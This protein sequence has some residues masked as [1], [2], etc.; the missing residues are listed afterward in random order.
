MSRA[1][2]SLCLDNSI[3]RERCFD[4]SPFV[5]YI[6]R[7][8]ALFR[9]SRAG[10]GESSDDE[11][12]ELGGRNRGA[13]GRALGAFERREQAGLSTE[14]QRRSDMD[15]WDPV[16]PGERVSWYNEYIQ[17][18]GPISVSWFQQSRVRDGG[19]ED[20][21][22]VRGVAL[23][24]PS[25]L[26]GSR[27]AVSPLDDGSVCLWDVSGSRGR[28]G[29]I[30]AKSKPGILFM[31]GPGGANTK[32]SKM[33]D[34]GVT[35]CVA[36]DSTGNRAFVAVQSRK[37][38]GRSACSGHKLKDYRPLGSRPSTA[39]NGEVRVIPVVDNCAVY[40]PPGQAPNGRH[41]AGHPSSRL[42][43]EKSTNRQRCRACR[44]PSRRLL[45]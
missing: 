18:S 35:E 2:R 37:S 21:V 29:A 24:S 7:K 10:A 39:G 40:C 38:T 19:L 42:S 36:V 4:E 17:R 44:R 26:P 14:Q 22:D 28:Q 1:L 15:N 16:F 20:I 23:Y 43:R 8:R 13:A 25:Q 33:I 30:V 11:D 45:R 5:D 27:M 34:T 31:D 12:E 6:Q 41:I 3:W 32:R 9:F